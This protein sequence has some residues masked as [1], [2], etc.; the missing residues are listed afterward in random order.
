LPTQIYLFTE[1]VTSCLF[2]TL[3][4]CWQCIAEVPVHFGCDDNFAVAVDK[5]DISLMELIGPCPEAAVFHSACVL[6][7][8]VSNIDATLLCYFL[9]WKC[10][11]F[12][13]FPN[14]LHY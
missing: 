6:A 4:N 10:T 12:L 7:E 11:G 1:F 9:F 14:F 2:K 13:D 5:S 8:Q 3:G